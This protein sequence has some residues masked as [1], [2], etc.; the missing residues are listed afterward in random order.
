MVGHIFK[1]K[2]QISIVLEYSH[3]KKYHGLLNDAFGEFLR[4]AIKE[5]RLCEADHL[6]AK[7]IVI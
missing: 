6:L 7:Y 4:Y 1:P 5:T 3:R 2:E